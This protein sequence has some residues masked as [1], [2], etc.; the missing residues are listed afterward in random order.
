MKDYNKPLKIIF[1]HTH[2][3]R[4]K[5]FLTQSDEQTWIFDNPVLK[6]NIYVNLSRLGYYWSG[7]VSIRRRH[8]LVTGC[9][10]VSTLWM[11]RDEEAVRGRK[12]VSFPCALIYGL[13]VQIDWDI[14]SRRWWGRWMSVCVCDVG[15]GWW[16]RKRC[17]WFIIYITLLLDISPFQFWLWITSYT[18][19]CR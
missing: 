12:F 7:Q 4:G 6:V 15:M 8:P 9:Q 14:T 17:E 3:L 18:R 16:W 19:I 11:G 10:A 5:T 1:D 13:I 2:R